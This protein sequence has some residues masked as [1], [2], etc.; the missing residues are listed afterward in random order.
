MN[1]FII[2]IIQAMNLTIIPVISMF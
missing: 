1:T 2:L